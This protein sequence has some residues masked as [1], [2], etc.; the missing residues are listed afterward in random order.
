MVFR[1]GQRYRDSAM[2]EFL[3]IEAKFRVEGV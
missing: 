2:Q 1:L 3:G